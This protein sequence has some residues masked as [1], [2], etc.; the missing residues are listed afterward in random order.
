MPATKSSYARLMA[1]CALSAQRQEKG[2]VL[3]QRAVP[4]DATVALAIYRKE[5]IDA[6]PLDFEN[7]V[8]H[9]DLQAAGLTCLAAMESGDM[10]LF[11][12]LLGWYHAALARHKLADESCWPANISNVEREERRRLHWYMYRLEVH[13]A[14]VLGHV[15]RCPELQCL[16]SYPTLPDQSHDEAEW[17]SGW[18]FVTDLYRGIEHLLTLFK[19]RRMVSTQQ[20]RKLNTDFRLDYRPEDHVLKPLA[21][22]LDELPTRFK[23]AEACSGLGA[24]NRCGF[25]AANIIC[26]YQ[27][28]RVVSFTASDNTFHDA[29]LTVMALIEE[30]STIPI[31]IMRAMSLGMLQELAG[32]GHLL[33]C[34]IK[35]GLSRPDYQH[36]RT[37][38]SCM[39]ELLDAL[40]SSIDSAAEAGER[41]RTYISAIDKHLGSIPAPTTAGIDHANTSAWL[42]DT[43]IEDWLPPEMHEI[44]WPSE[45]SDQFFNSLNDV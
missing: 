43:S 12:R 22:A 28:L 41:L 7:A 6:L 16:V 26:T 45:W 10:E 14:L 44:P 19:A 37:A 29:C 27:L 38:L 2:A 4:T 5:V 15:V 21:A 25:Q 23:H 11:H 35:R 20:G 1:M 8:E 3:S 9:S 13:S 18:N 36:L 39:L 40:A 31:D 17:L 32:F 24:R 33:S 30:I 34:F 42:A